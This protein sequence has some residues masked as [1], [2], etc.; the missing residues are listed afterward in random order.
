VPDILIGRWKSYTP[1]V[2]ASVLDVLLGRAGWQ[3]KLLDSVAK[4]IVPAGS[5]D[6]ARRQRLLDHKDQEVRRRAAEVFVGAGQ[7]DRQKVLEEYG[8]SLKMAADATRGKAVFAKRCAICHQ[9]QGLGHVVGPDL[10]P[11]ANKTRLYLLTEILDPNRNIDS[12]YVEYLAVTK[13]GRT[14]TGLL[15][16]ESAASI[17]LRGQE[18][19]EQTL[20]R[21][22]L[23]SFLSTGKSLMPEGLEKDLSKQEMA[24]VIKYLTA[25]PAGSRLDRDDR[26]AGA[27]AELP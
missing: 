4:N 11:L 8:V 3:M 2:K 1:A 13:A 10:A 26:R 22:E 17:T 24:D 25:A 12:R 23:E 6:A 7:R 5:I 21:G 20:L 19:K 16:S 15:A 27:M 14:F 18:G 9:L